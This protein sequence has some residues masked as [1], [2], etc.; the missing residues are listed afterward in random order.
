MDLLRPQIVH[1]DASITFLSP[2]KCFA[3]VTDELAFSPPWP[4][5]FPLYF[6][7]FFSL[8]SFR[9]CQVRPPGWTR[10]FRA[11]WPLLC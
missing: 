8:P 7:F 10:S 3:P 2:S 6:L 11:V 4:P 5:V 9:L 1:D